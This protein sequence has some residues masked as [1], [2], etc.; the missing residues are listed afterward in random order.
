MEKQLI[1]SLVSDQT[2]PNVQIIKEFGSPQTD[3]M[4]ILT[5]KMEHKGTAKWIMET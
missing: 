5:E 4:L 2:I 1:I 3:Y